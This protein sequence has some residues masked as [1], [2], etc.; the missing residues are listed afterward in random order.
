MATYIGIKGIEIPSVASD[1]SNPVAGQVWYNTGSATLK[2]Y[3]AQGTGAWASGG[4]LNSGRFHIVGFGIQTAALVCGG[5]SPPFPAALTETYNGSTWSVANV[6]NTARNEAASALHGST[7]A[8]LIS[9][10]GPDQAETESWDGTNW[11]EVND[12]NTSR[13][14]PVG[15]GT[16]TA[17]LTFGGQTSPTTYMNE[18]ETWNGT[19]WTEGNNLNTGRNAAGGAGTQTAAMTFGGRI[20][21]STNKT[22]TYDGT[23]WT[24]V[25][26]LNSARNQARGSG[27]Q[28][29]ALY[30]GGEPAPGAIVE[31]WN[32]TAWT[33]IADLATPRTGMGAAGTGLLSVAAGGS[34][35]ATEEFT[36]PD[37][38]KTFTV[39]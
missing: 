29:A 23:S 3:G 25:A 24:E 11:T 14:S 18:S 19:S 38:T 15:A 1:P 27:G 21:A 36:V 31:S 37:A 8:G 28:T 34:P 5:N 32:G 10:G 9:G 6:L 13:R 12:L 17:A 2:G 39:S 33:E 16:Q 26:N 4:A 22:E 7:T 35:P 30:I 20:P